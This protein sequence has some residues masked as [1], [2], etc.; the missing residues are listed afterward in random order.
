MLCV[1][2]KWPSE[3]ANSA[4]QKGK[5]GGLS[6]RNQKVSTQAACRAFVIP[7]NAGIQIGVLFTGHP[8]EFIL[9]EVEGRV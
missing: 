9:S 3:M 6:L 1:N 5:Q 2:N 8:L 7:A 4:A